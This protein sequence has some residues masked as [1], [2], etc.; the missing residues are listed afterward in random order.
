MCVWGGGDRNFLLPFPLSWIEGLS[1]YKWDEEGV[2][3]NRTEEEEEEEE[4][5]KTHLC[6]YYHTVFSLPKQEKQRWR[7]GLHVLCC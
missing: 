1:Y 5:N 7:E 4:D 3:G 2:E 6:Q